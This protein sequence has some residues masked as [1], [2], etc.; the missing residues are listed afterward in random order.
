[1]VTLFPPTSRQDEIDAGLP[2]ED[3]EAW[4]AFVDASEG[5]TEADDAPPLGSCRQRVWRGNWQLAVAPHGRTVVP[6]VVPLPAPE[7]VVVAPVATVRP[8]LG[9]W[10]A[11]REALRWF[12]QPVAPMTD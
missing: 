3:E 10:P 2:L 6:P 7:P 1:M 9:S 8:G 5:H 12:F 11:F 4:Q